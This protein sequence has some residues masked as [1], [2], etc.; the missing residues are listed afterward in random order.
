M[1]RRW[2]LLAALVHAAP[3]NKTKS[4]RT[5]AWPPAHLLEPLLPEKV[6]QNAYIVG[7]CGLGHR[8]SRLMKTYVWA[9]SRGKHVVVNWGSCLGPKLEHLV[10]NFYSALFDDWNEAVGFRGEDHHMLMSPAC[11]GDGWCRL[12]DFQKHSPENVI[13]NEPSKDWKPPGVQFRRLAAENATSRRLRAVSVPRPG[14]LGGGLSKGHFFMFEWGMWLMHESVFK[15][16]EHF[17][18][19][20]VHAL[21]PEW[22]RLLDAFILDEFAPHDA[23]AGHGRARAR[24]I[25]VHF[26]LGNGEA[27][28]RNPRDHE[29][30]VLRTAAAV[31]TV[32]ATLGYER[33]R[34][35]VATDDASALD[36]L[37]QRTDL[38]VFA[39]PQWRPKPGAG[40]VFSSWRVKEVDTD[41]SVAA[42]KE[43][44]GSA[45]ACLRNSADMLIDSLLLGYADALV[46]PIAST[47][48]VLPKVMAHSRGAPY[49]A[50]LGED[51]QRDVST[52]D[53]TLRCFR[54]DPKTKQAADWTVAVR[55]E[56][57]V[58]HLGASYWPLG[59]PP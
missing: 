11:G 33:Y 22:R 43:M 7:C 6:A 38:D 10:R 57:G 59:A 8:T 14:G 26:R 41:K 32:A 30:V 23:S 19:N 34:V 28:G 39:R 48:T 52:V 27:F 2:L 40:I 53:L 20:A 47:F 16:A 56:G 12:K 50:F 5:R 58:S 46:L 42:Q 3:H 36:I 13:L 24:V 25:G 21:K 31:R 9:V 51:W 18:A 35:F 15:Y 54:R 17:A 4:P 44:T 45:D 1:A 55:R 37:R 29:H 49:C